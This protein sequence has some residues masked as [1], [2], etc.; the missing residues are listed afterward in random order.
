MEKFYQIR[1]VS[2]LKGSLNFTTLQAVSQFLLLRRDFGY[3]S[4]DFFLTLYWQ[5][6]EHRPG[7][8]GKERLR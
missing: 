6:G 3:N 4:E 8:D 1:L 5:V 7:G 2:C